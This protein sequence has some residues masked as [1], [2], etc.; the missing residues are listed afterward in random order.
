MPFTFQTGDKNIS[1]N[2]I[3]NLGQISEYVTLCFNSRG[4]QDRWSP[5]SSEKGKEKAAAFWALDPCPEQLFTCLLLQLHLSTACCGRKPACTLFHLQGREQFAVRRQQVALRS[6]WPNVHAL[7]SIS[8]LEIIHLLTETISR[9]RDF[10][11]FLP[12]TYLGR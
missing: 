10:V 2:S 7:F 9:A 1:S 6:R 3:P 11:Y 12:L 4:E 8:V 5:E